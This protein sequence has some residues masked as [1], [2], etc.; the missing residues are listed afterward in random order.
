[1]RPIIG[2]G[3]PL[4]LDHTDLLREL[5]PA[6]RAR[7]HDDRGRHPRAPSRAAGDDTFFLTGTDEHA[8][9]VYRV[10]EERGLDAKA[11]VDQIV[12]ENWRPLPAR[13]GSRAGLLH[14]DD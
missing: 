9:K 8:S 7:V 6:H 14:P 13:V 10:A 3:E 1:M 5:D 2:F 11:F 4:L 12:E